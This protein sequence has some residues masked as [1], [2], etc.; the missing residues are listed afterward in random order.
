MNNFF[1]AT[2]QDIQQFLTT[3]ILPLSMLKQDSVMPF[4][5]VNRYQS[6]YANNNLKVFSKNNS[7][8][9]L[10]FMS[11][12]NYYTEDQNYSIFTLVKPSNVNG[13]VYPL[14]SPFKKTVNQQNVSSYKQLK[15]EFKKCFGIKVVEKNNISG[16]SQFKNKSF[17]KSMLFYADRGLKACISILTFGKKKF[18]SNPADKIKGKLI[19]KHSNNITG[20]PYSEVDKLAKMYNFVAVKLTNNLYAKNK[21]TSVNE[22]AVKLISSLIAT[23][24]VCACA[25]LGSDDA[26]SNLF[27]CLSLQISNSFASLKSLSKVDKQNIVTLATKTTEAMLSK[28]KRTPENLIENIKN[29]GF[30]IN[31]SENSNLEDIIFAKQFPQQEKVVEVNTVKEKPQVIIQVFQEKPEEKTE[32]KSKVEEKVKTETTLK[33]KTAKEKFDNGICQTFAEMIEK[34]NQ[35]IK[36]AKTK[37]RINKLISER[38]FIQSILGN[39]EVVSYDFA[40]SSFETIRQEAKNKI[41]M[42]RDEYAKIFAIK[43]VE[44]R[45][46]VLDNYFDEKSIKQEKLKELKTSCNPLTYAKFLNKIFKKEFS[47]T[48]TSTLKTSIKNYTLNLVKLALTKLNAKKSNELEK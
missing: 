7:D 31:V 40:K 2:S 41:P 32:E 33:R 4:E 17:A 46:K 3:G 45:N 8:S 47:E 42:T 27:A 10:K 15:D 26:N 36:N 21:M 48:E 19:I 11:E 37:T 39:F 12:A 22:N 23:Q 24:Y 18:T 38:D 43:I 29:I 9:R 5:I 6:I 30:N 28:L 16:L 44:K 1:K 13:M 14:P 35:N 20:K 25:D 34:Y